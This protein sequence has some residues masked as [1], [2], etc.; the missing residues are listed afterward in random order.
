M[1][2]ERLLRPAQ[3]ATAAF[4]GR[5]LADAMGAAQLGLGELHQGRCVDA[6]S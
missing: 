2:P 3:R 6:T 1:L 4:L 5:P